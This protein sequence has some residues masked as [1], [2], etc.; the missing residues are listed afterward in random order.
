MEDTQRIRYTEKK[1]DIQRSKYKEG[2]IYRK[3]KAEEQ[4]WR[5]RET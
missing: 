4:I 5:G 2:E 3:T 1:K